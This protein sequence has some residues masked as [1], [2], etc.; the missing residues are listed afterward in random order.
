MK[1]NAIPYVRFSRY[2]GLNFVIHGTRSWITKYVFE[3]FGQFRSNIF[4]ITHKFKQMKVANFP[5]V[6]WTD[7]FY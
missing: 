4:I 5:L 1:A 3:K 7:N 2:F 6:G